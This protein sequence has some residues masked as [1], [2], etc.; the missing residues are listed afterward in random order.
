MGRKKLQVLISA[1]VV[2]SIAI[3]ARE[4]LTYYTALGKAANVVTSGDVQ[5]RIYE[6]TADG[7]DFPKDGIAVMPGKVVS[8][9]VTI[10]NVCDQPFYLRVKL[11]KSMGSE[12]LPEECLDIDINTEKWT[13]RED[14]YAYYNH[15]VEPGQIT[16]P[17]FSE[18][19]IVGDQVDQQYMGRVLSLTVDAQAVQSKNNPA[20]FPW[21]ASGWPAE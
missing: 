16:E 4:T 20:D 8:K 5:L 3:V 10:E 2:I 9:I 21:E 18:V 19:E 13:L 6:K 15:I 17:V 14:G 7:G 11:T 12:T 1:L